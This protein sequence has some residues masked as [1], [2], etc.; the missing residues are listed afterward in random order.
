MKPTETIKELIQ[1]VT[2]FVRTLHAIAQELEEQNRK[3]YALEENRKVKDAAISALQKEVAT[4][5]LLARRK[6]VA[7]DAD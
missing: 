1:Q 7:A 5:K 2:L 4:L 6:V 3:I